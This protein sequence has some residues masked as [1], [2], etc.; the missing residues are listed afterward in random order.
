MVTKINSKE[1]NGAY[2]QATNPRT[3]L[4]TALYEQHISFISLPPTGNAQCY[5]IRQ[6][7]KVD[8]TIP[9]LAHCPL[10]SSVKMDR[11]PKLK[12]G[13][14][15]FRSAEHGSYFIQHISSNGQKIKVKQNEI[16]SSFQQRSI[17]W[18]Q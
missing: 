12:L 6:I 8:K 3:R 11:K 13:L 17:Q 4:G 15:L 1:K 18:E 14:L 7:C 5:R 10:P 2:Q 9:C 16:K